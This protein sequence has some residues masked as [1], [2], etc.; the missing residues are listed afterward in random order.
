MC[1]SFQASRI[2]DME[3]RAVPV[4]PGQKKFVRPHLNGKKAQHGSM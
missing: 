2:V 3:R 1:L 4:Q